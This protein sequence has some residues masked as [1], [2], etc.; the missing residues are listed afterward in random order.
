VG[1]CAF[2]HICGQPILKQAKWG[3]GFVNSKAINGSQAL[4]TG[5]TAPLGCCKVGCP[6]ACMPVVNSSS[7]PLILPST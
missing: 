2:V 7:N 6:L 1:L 5:L 3:R 4:P